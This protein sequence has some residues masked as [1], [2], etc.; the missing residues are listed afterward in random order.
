MSNITVSEAQ[1]RNTDHANIDV[2]LTR[3]RSAAT[4]LTRCSIRRRIDLAEACL[5]GIDRIAKTWVE[6][7]CE[8]KQIPANSPARAE[9][10]TAG[11]VSVLRYLRLLIRTLNDIEK[12]GKPRLPG[13]VRHENEQCIVP[14]FPTLEAPTSRGLIRSTNTP[15]SSSVVRKTLSTWKIL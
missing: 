2:A 13:K 5:E 14:V 3:L 15:I 10:I 7:A 6:T 9:E 1:Q 11:P 4:D 8:A 12:S